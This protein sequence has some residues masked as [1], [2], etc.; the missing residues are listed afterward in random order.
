MQIVISSALQAVTHLTLAGSGVSQRVGA[1]PME[2]VSI[3]F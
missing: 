2:I 1:T 3:C